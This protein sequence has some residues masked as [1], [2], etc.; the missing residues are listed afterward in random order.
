M[1]NFILS[2]E[3]KNAKYLEGLLVAVLWSFIILFLLP[4]SCAKQD[5]NDR[6][7]VSKIKADSGYYVSSSDQLI[8]EWGDKNA[9]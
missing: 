7:H 3:G 4:S 9:K 6:K 2:F 1:K 8:I 5:L